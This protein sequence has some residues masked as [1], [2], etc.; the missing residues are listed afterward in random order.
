MIKRS[1]VS[2]CSYC[3]SF[4]SYS[5]FILCPPL[6]ISPPAS[7][8]DREKGKTQIKRQIFFL[9]YSCGTCLNFHGRGCC[10]RCR[11]SD[12]TQPDERE[13]CVVF[14]VLLGSPALIRWEES[15]EQDSPNVTAAA[16]AAVAGWMFFWK[17]N[18][19]ETARE[20]S[21]SSVDH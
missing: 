6:H 12:Q 13:F 14:F 4:A 21:V 17:E 2:W 15:R 10:S 19:A 8:W 5:F 11:I 3:S 16:A 18:K 9:S 1:S 20:S 7:C